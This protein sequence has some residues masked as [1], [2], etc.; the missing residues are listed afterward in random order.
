MKT[1]L[2]ESPSNAR[3]LRVQREYGLQVMIAAH[4]VRGRFG[5]VGHSI[6]SRPAALLAR[7]F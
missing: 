6:S 7:G 1:G 4:G 5:G 3:S 2:A